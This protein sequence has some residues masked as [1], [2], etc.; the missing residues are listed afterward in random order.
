MNY[1]RIF[2]VNNC[3]MIAT[4]IGVGYFPPIYQS[5]P[6]VTTPYL[7]SGNLGKGVYF[8]E[9]GL[10]GAIGYR[11]GELLNGRVISPMVG[12]RYQPIKRR[13]A[14]FRIYSTYSKDISIKES[15]LWLGFSLGAL[16]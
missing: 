5:K 1:E 4:Q 8:F 10:A 7:V 11:N 13:S 9:F 14:N 6:L 12:Y 3:F 2:P 16:F 15:Y